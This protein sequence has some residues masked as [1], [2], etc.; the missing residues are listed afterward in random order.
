[1]YREGLPYVNPNEYAHEGSGG[2]CGWIIR[3]F[4]HENEGEFRSADVW[5]WLPLGWWRQA[6]VKACITFEQELLLSK[7][8][9]LD[10]AIQSIAIN[11]SGIDR[12]KDKLV[13]FLK[14]SR[15][16]LVAIGEKTK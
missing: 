15:T 7:E 13:R 14:A 8:A 16:E 11:K 2:L 1:M 9:G 12:R 5:N 6:R 4:Y 3:T 10:H